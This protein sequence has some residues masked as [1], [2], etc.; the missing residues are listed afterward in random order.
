[1]SNNDSKFEY[2]VFKDEQLVEFEVCP[3]KA[4]EAYDKTLKKVAGTNIPVTLVERRVIRS[5]S[6]KISL[7]K[8]H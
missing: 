3:V 8:K 4:N 1:M 7:T 2:L 6:S 5:N